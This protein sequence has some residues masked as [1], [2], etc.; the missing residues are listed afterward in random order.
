MGQSMASP[1][2]PL[3]GLHLQTPLCEL[4]EEG[5]ISGFYKRYVVDTFAIMPN[6]VETYA[7]LDVQLK[8]YRTKK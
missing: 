6:T 7:F 3:A 2:I 8:T 4:Q 5:A 1:W